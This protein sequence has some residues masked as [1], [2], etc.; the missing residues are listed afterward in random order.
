MNDKND[1][2]ITGPR[3]LNKQDDMIP[4]IPGT[5][6]HIAS[7]SDELV[8]LFAPL[9]EALPRS[10]PPAN[11]FAAIEAEIDGEDAIVPQSQRSDEGIWVQRDDKVWKK[12]LASD[13]QTGRS[14]Y[15]LRCLPGAR[16]KSHVHERSEQ[17][18]I[19]E[20]SFWMDGKL[21]SSGDAQ[22]S[23]PGTEHC[24]ITMPSGCLV[25]VSA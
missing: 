11:L 12:T 1:N 3:T 17:L 9:T 2:V 10:D 15:L 25:L 7:D 5:H 23:M 19:I 21:Y 4:A 6:P 22:C 24:E 14:M 16:I 20:G 8:D 13:P 18:F